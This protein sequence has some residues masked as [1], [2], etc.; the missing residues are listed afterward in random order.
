MLLNLYCGVKLKLIRY[1]VIFKFVYLIVFKMYRI[2]RSL[3]TTEELFSIFT[4][5]STSIIF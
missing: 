3:K 5:F 1:L 2:K 4:N